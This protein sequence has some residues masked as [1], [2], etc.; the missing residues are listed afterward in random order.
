QGWFLPVTPGTKFITV[1]GAVANDVHGK[2]HH[3]MGTF[4][5]HVCALELARS[6]GSRSFCS[7]TQN[8][9]L[10]RATIGGLGLTGLI[11]WV[12]LRLRKVQSPFITVENIKYRNLDEFFKLAQES[13]SAFEHTVAWVDCLASG[14]KLGRGVFM[15]GNGT[16]SA[17]APSAA[18]KR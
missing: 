6:D 8:A 18:T 9:D 1:A 3:L 16:T 4:G 11:T 7:A 10:F 13:E 17:E 14:G 5:E 12:E 2:N 15:R